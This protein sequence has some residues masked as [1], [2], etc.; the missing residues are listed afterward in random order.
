MSDLTPEENAYRAVVAQVHARVEE[1]LKLLMNGTPACRL[2]CERPAA[3]NISQ[4]A[5]DILGSEPVGDGTLEIQA[6]EIPMDR[7][8]TQ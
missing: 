4:P 6:V 1:R 8:L 2:D 5:E 7:V 3:P